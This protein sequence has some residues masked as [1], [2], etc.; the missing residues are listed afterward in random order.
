MDLDMQRKPK[1]RNRIIFNSIFILII[2]IASIYVIRINNPS[3]WI[4]K[5]QENNSKL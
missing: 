4:D 5:T 1:S 3:V 2:L